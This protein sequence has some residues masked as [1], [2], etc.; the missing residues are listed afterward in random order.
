MTAHSL[1]K[2]SAWS[3]MTGLALVALLMVEIAIGQSRS[4][5]LPM[6][7]AA[8]VGFELFLFVDGMM[9]RVRHRG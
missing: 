7:L 9:R 8:V 1:Q 3:A 6:L 4:E 2:L 5:I